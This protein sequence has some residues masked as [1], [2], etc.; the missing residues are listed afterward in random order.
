M[1]FVCK[2]KLSFNGSNYCADLGIP[3]GFLADAAPNCSIDPRLFRVSSLF[4]SWP[5]RQT[6]ALGCYCQLRRT[7]LNTV[8][9]CHLAMQR[10]SLPA[11]RASCILRPRTWLD[12]TWVKVLLGKYSLHDCRQLLSASFTLL[13]CLAC[14]SAAEYFMNLAS[15]SSLVGHAGRAGNPANQE[16][17]LPQP[18]AVN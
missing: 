18:Q 7:Q 14:Q 9:I 16:T 15:T 5:V 8:L 11:W 12:G 13:L 2:A 17:N 10:F 1:S 4:I 6:A 3:K